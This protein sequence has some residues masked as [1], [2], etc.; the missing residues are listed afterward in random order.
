M[1]VPRIEAD[2][3]IRFARGTWR[4]ALCAVHVSKLITLVIDIQ[5]GLKLNGILKIAIT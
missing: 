1:H 2:A 3:E 4:L 5:L